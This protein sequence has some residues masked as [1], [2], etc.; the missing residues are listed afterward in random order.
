MK[1]I[2]FVILHSFC[3]LNCLSQNKSIV[4]ADFT[5]KQALPYATIKILNA[6]RGYYSDKNG[7]VKISTLEKDTLLIEYAGYVSNVIALD[8]ISDTVFIQRKEYELS[9]VEIKSSKVKRA[10]GNFKYR[11]MT[12]FFFG[13]SR[14][15]AIKID[16]SGIEGSYKVKQ[17]F[18]PLKINKKTFKDCV[19]KL[20]LYKESGDG[21]PG[22][23]V[24]TKPVFLTQDSLENDFFIDVA[25]Q[26]I[27]VSEKYLFIGIECI[28]DK[29][30]PLYNPDLSERRAFI[31]RNRLSPISFYF[32]KSDEFFDGG[33]GHTFTRL[34]NSLSYKWNRNTY[35]KDPINFPAGLIILSSK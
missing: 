20:H 19:V 4:I 13:D 35:S 31:Q 3:S 11:K 15:Y 33:Y 22:E 27:I 21:G 2:V 17:I 28:I 6:I 1:V 9:P 7:I 34:L 26:N 18:M 16:L 29:I 32:S 12:D 23:D 14:E 8:S 25:W 24:L 5:D 30:T 10:V